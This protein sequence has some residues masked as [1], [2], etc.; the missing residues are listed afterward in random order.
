MYLLRVCFVR[1]VVDY[2]IKIVMPHVLFE[3]NNII[4]HYKTIGMK[5]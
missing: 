4:Q 1:V 2:E 5:T 3:A